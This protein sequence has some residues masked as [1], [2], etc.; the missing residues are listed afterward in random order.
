M[1]AAEFQGGMSAQAR[2]QN[3]FCVIHF[4]VQQL[5]SRT[6]SFLSFAHQLLS[7]PVYGGGVE[8]A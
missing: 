3:H 6:Y 5:C 1:L 8:R 7:S 2:P 4:G